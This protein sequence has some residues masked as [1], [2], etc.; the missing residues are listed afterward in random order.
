NVLGDEP[1]SPSLAPVSGLLKVIPQE[2][3]GVY[4]SHIDISAKEAQRDY[5]V[6]EIDADAFLH[7]LLDEIGHREQ[8]KSVALR[9]S[10]RWVPVFEW[11][12][13]QPGSAS[14]LHDLPVKIR[15]RGVYLITGGLGDLG[16]TLSK[17]LINK[18]N[19]RLILLGRTAL[20]PDEANGFR[21]MRMRELE[22][23]GGDVLYV[24]CDIADAAAVKEAVNT[25]ESK[26][27]MIDGVIHAAGISGAEARKTINIMTRADL[28][29]QF[30]AK[31][32]GLQILK[33]LFDKRKPDF[34]LAT[35]SIS[36][37]LGGLGFGVYTPANTFM[38]HL[39]NA[40]K[41]STEEDPW[42]S[43][44]L[45]GL[46]LKK[47]GSGGITPE[48]LC[49]LFEHVISLT[50]IPNIAIS[51][52]DLNRRIDKWVRLRSDEKASFAGDISKPSNAAEKNLLQS[53]TKGPGTEERL[54]NLWKLFFGIADIGV[55]DDFFGIG[56]D[57]LK[58]MVIISRIN[59]EFNT[60]LSV[61]ELFT[62]PT[63]RE[64]VPILKIEISQMG[65]ANEDR[66]IQSGHTLIPIAANQEFYPLSSAQK[67]LFFL[68][69]FDKDSLVY[70]LTLLLGLKGAPDRVRI[71]STFDRLLRRHESLRTCFELLNNDPVQKIT[72]PDNFELEY[73]NASENNLESVFRA[74]V[75]PFELDRPP[76]IRAGL[77]AVSGNA[78]DPGNSA[79]HY[80]LMVDLHHI[81][82]DGFSEGVLIRD[83]IALYNNEELPALPLQ[84]KDYAQWQQSDEQR[85]SVSRQKEFWL[86]EFAEEIPTLQLP[87][88]FPRPSIKSYEGNTLAFELGEQDVRGLRLVAEKEGS[89]LFMVLL[90]IYAILLSKLSDQE[91]IVIGT[92]VAG[93][94]QA[95]LQPII[96]M[97]VNT[98][99]IRNHANKQLRFQEFLA[100]VKSNTIR[101]FDNQGYQY[102]DLIDALRP[103]RD[104]SHNPLFDVLFSYGN[105]SRPELVL[106]D[107]SL[108]RLDYPN[109]G[110]K[111][112]LT[113][114]VNDIQD[115]LFFTFE[116]CTKLFKKETIE[117]F[118][119]YFRKIVTTVTATPHVLLKDVELLDEAAK[120]RL[121]VEFNA[122]ELD[123]SEGAT[124]VSLFEE[125]VKRTPHKIAV[126]YEDMHWT[127]QELNESANRVAFYLRE[128]AGIKR[129]DL[130]GI[131]VS[132][133]GKMMAGLLGILKAGGAY[134]PIDPAY[135]KQRVEHMLTDSGAA[136]LITDKGRAIDFAYNGKGLL[137]EDILNAAG[138]TAPA[139]NK[140]DDLCYVMYTSGSTGLPKGVMITHGAVVN[141][142]QGMSRKLPAGETD[143]LLAVTSTSFDISVLEL[144]WTICNGIQVIVHPSDISLNGLDRYVDT[145]AV[146][147]DFSLFFFSSYSNDGD[148]KYDLLLDS[149]K[150][151]DKQGF[152]AVWTPERHFHE[153]GGLFPN[154]SVL[155]SALAMITE[156][157][158]LRSG[159]VVLPLHDEIRIAEEWSVVDNLSNGRV[160]LSFASGW[161]PNDFILSED[162][163]KDRQ[164]IMYEKIRVVKDLWRGE[165]IS[166]VNGF[167][168]T[169]E[170]RI[171]PE[172][173]QKELP[174][175][176]TSGGSADTFISAG[177]IGA[178]ILTHLLGQDIDSLAKNIQ[179][180]RGSR[181]KHGFDPEK[182]KVAIMLHTYIGEQIEEVEK[183]VE[184]P[185]M[186]YLKSS[187][188]LSKVLFEEEGIKEEELPEED[189]A[190]VLKS[191]FKRYYTTSSLIGTKSSCGEILMKLAK[192]GVDEIACL[193][194]FGIDKNKV[195]EGLQ[196]LSELKRMYAGIFPGEHQPVTMMQSTPSFINL[197]EK[198]PGSKKFLGSLKM[199][200]IGGEAVP[201]S[202]MRNIRAIT[203][204][205]VFNMY[206]PTETTI[207]SCVHA[208]DDNEDKVSIGKPIANTQIYILNKELQP[209]PIGVTGDLYIGGRG[210][211]RGYWN[212]PVLTAQ[213][214]IDNPF[215]PGSKMYLT[216]DVARWTSEGNLEFLGR[217]DHQV[218][219]RGYR[220]ELG[221]IEHTLLTYPMVREAIVDVRE[222][223]SV[224]QLT[225]YLAADPAIDLVALRTHLADS[226]PPYMIP[227]HFVIMDRLPLTSNGKVNRKA[228]P[229]PQDNGIRNDFE[230]PGT[231][232]ERLL[233]EVWSKVLGVGNISITDNFFSLGGDSIKSIQI[234]SRMRN[235]GYEISAKD[236]FIS[237]TIRMLAQRVKK[238]GSV[239]DQSFIT[240]TGSL[241]P[242]QRWYFDGISLDA[243]H[244]NQAVMLLFPNGISRDIVHT[245][246]RK[247]QE[248][249]DALRMVF[250]EVDGSFIPETRGPDLPVAISES[251][252]RKE[253][254]QAWALNLYA[255]KVQSGI[256]LATGPLMQLG[257][258]HMHDGSRL[259]IAIHHLVVDGIS[260]RILFEDIEQLY[261]QVLHNK[262]LSL[263]LKTDSFQSWPGHLSSYMQSKTWQQA[264]VYWRKFANDF[265]PSTI[266]RIPRDYPGGINTGAVSRME[267]FILDAPAT[268]R[269]LTEAHH[270]FNTRVNDLM[271][272]AL[273]LSVKKLYKH[274][275]LMLDLEGHG[276]EDIG[277][278]I[279]ISRTVG[280]FTS[281]FRI[282]I[283]GGQKDLSDNIKNIKE[284][285][286]RIPNAGLDYLL[287]KYAEGSAAST[288]NPQMSFNYLGQFDADIEGNSFTIVRG[289]EGDMVSPKASLPYDWDIVGS[290]TAGEL[291]MHLRYSTAQ[292]R[293]E[294]VHSFMNCYKDSLLEV[295]DYCC[296]YGR[297][298]L[299]PSDM[300]YKGLS[301]DALDKLQQEYAIKDIYPLTPTQEGILYH[302]LIDKE[303][304][305]F[306]IQTTCLLTGDLNLDAIGKS[307]N[308]LMARYDILR[309]IFLHEGYQQHIQVVL[310]DRRI[311]LSCEDIRE[312][313]PESS[314]K[315]L[316]RK[317]QL[318]ERA[319]AFDPDRDVLM[320]LL[321][322]RTGEREY[323]FI[324]NYHHLL[325]DGWCIGI[326]VNEFTT[327]YQHM[328]SRT[329]IR[330]P[331]V[332]PYSH[333]IEWL[334]NRDK[335][336]SAAFWGQYLAGYENRTGLPKLTTLSQGTAASS[337][338]QKTWQ[339]IIDQEQTQG[340]NRLSRQYGVTIN[341]ILQGCWG[342]LLARYNNTD[343]VVFG[344]VVSGRPAEIEGVETMVGL[345]I[346]TIPVRIKYEG[347]ATAGDFL[348]ELQ[349]SALESELYHYHPLS[350]IQSMREPGRELLDHI[351]AFENFPIA[352]QIGKADGTSTGKPF[353]IS[354]ADFFVQGNYDLDITIMPLDELIIQFDF[355][356]NRYA[357]KTIENAGTQLKNIISAIVAKPDG[358]LKD[359]SLYDEREQLALNAWLTADLEQK[360]TPIQLRL[361]RS[362]ETHAHR[363]AIE[364]RGKQYSYKEIGADAGKIA[365]AIAGHGIAEGSFVGI[366]CED[367]RWLISSMLGILQSRSAFVPLETTLPGSRLTS[368]ISQAGIRYIITDQQQTDCERIDPSGTITWLTIDAIGHQKVALQQLRD[369]SPEDQIYVYF[370]SGS[371]GNPKG[372][373][374]R[375]K[376]LSHFIE[377]EIGT[378][379][380]DSSHRFSQFVNPG[381]DAFMRDIFVPLCSG[382]TICIPDEEN[383]STAPRIRAWI[384]SQRIDLIHCVP[385]FFKLFGKGDLQEVLYPALKYVLLAGE[386]ILPYELQEWH[387]AFGERIRLVNLY[388]ATETT[389]VKGYRFIE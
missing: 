227:A 181:A 271:L 183:I 307:M 267:T 11:L 251:D 377:W 316:I 279:N 301:I 371:T 352:Q 349:A 127:Y 266:D 209:V 305:R 214:F 328:V 248:H 297:T 226:L 57:S 224:K 372:V 347:T 269:L 37:I 22:Q 321:I 28:E 51:V 135:P 250:K 176:I 82:F 165:K 10:K 229:D 69:E 101:C 121:L 33:D 123:D 232:N 288:A 178:N 76:L 331:S 9:N 243:H 290:V 42:I 112:D 241:T 204:A 287:V 152:K 46:D 95:D 200:L 215:R 16:F 311:G 59:K 128:Q 97:F 340:L 280:W 203:R 87:F 289:L 62:N 237:Q 137:L 141:F 213:R 319:R 73:Y 212:K 106:P 65:I 153:F 4:T 122:T 44:G 180:Y 63:V 275:S 1:V 370:T 134:L 102:E 15:H 348:Q 293:E 60:D 35:S 132:R 18:Y 376:G 19:T 156:K 142:F 359:I 258:F 360:T 259:L 80:I 312:V 131:M 257:L 184:Q 7:K 171:F 67:R 295:I 317:Y 72:D 325:M 100:N 283:E 125:Q 182:G 115:R 341:T 231:E 245:I 31:A 40:F 146:S 93:R 194:D 94:D 23:M 99:P 342:I 38:D 56:G 126:V 189:R 43:V 373:V 8:G 160:A 53:D 24:S 286:R 86:N 138:D 378:F 195:M 202:L 193:V 25:G 345:F 357:E 166:R 173:V 188:G 219:I 389:L 355:N 369:Y 314:K 32:T 322:I 234:I 336:A 218:K 217:S 344:S 253:Q 282:L 313:F 75:R 154:P 374:G 140:P 244:Y 254:D 384:D 302:S 110:S 161:N 172:P 304:S 208:F 198:D 104:T 387:Q 308:Y 296:S 177:A 273:F 108:E 77:V 105:F 29:Y 111:F 109:V 364:Y 337:Y 362:F 329:E 298:E 323:E 350:E 366:F 116:Y 367:R 358:L 256:D 252:L 54:L 30:A 114:T 365:A 158:E 190:R 211:S 14:V 52:G 320:R 196:H 90:S 382:G 55:D 247:I 27:G 145:A 17:Y 36:V 261:Q 333:Y 205:A 157:I 386:K 163:F 356:A 151:A 96:G 79:D 174:V 2:Y 309:T 12:F 262:P 118:E 272:T 78:A 240:G 21:I 149:V 6:R 239:S 64:L 187:L 175:W 380:I 300:S 264:A 292:Y 144:F 351:I 68:N 159:S 291:K 185:F 385:S 41:N 330:L 150:Y 242:I 368:M 222:K 223:E 221:E 83:F 335:E 210:L 332:K 13:E 186:E 235:A 263:P 265:P 120:R 148:D 278:G 136:I 85:Q 199:L 143:C 162:N 315:E 381:F 363:S 71:Q 20:T 216:G 66:V 58:A 74:F 197:L 179:L 206:G 326:L 354:N 299:T 268:I 167:G 129:E 84:Y 107:L 169:T 228:L 45:D 50:N 294:T 147:L 168:S 284:T 361:H 191:A 276:R 379:H 270:A 327:I 92:P 285:L 201:E 103:E 26:F 334:G 306:N 39:I 88:D 49:R 70:N 274:T 339:V 338:D 117:R 353:E 91:D 238:T 255:N 124:I 246:F 236:I 277:Q 324:W 89:T 303:A 48:E 192:A 388:G 260:W 233:A 155:S 318:Q 343:D 249:H 310:K 346:N 61:S 170:L 383:L 113:L 375:N 81:I 47:E 3:S 207:W 119:Q 34:C 130:V 220:I 281:I 98:I 164:T 225:A 5:A 139:I 230:A 133:S